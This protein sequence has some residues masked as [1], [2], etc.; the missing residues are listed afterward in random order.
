MS[1]NATIQPQPDRSSP[2]V[3]VTLRI[4]VKTTLSVVAAA[5][6]LFDLLVRIELAQTM[7]RA[8]MA[9][10]FGLSLPHAFALMIGLAAPFALMAGLG[11]RMSALVLGGLILAGWRGPLI[12]PADL[13]LLALLGWYAVRGAGALSVDRV[14]A[15]GL[16]GSALPLAAP[17]M[18][19]LRFASQSLAPVWLLILRLWLAL[20]LLVAAGA[21]PHELSALLPTELY[22]LVVPSSALPLAILLTVGLATPLVILLVFLGL[23]TAMVM[24]GHVG[25]LFLPTLLLGGVSPWHTELTVPPRR[26]SQSPYMGENRGR[27]S[28]DRLGRE[29]RRGAAEG[30]QQPCGLCHD[31]SGRNERSLDFQLH[32]AAAHGRAHRLRNRYYRETRPKSGVR[33]RAVRQVYRCPGPHSGG[34]AASKPR[35]CINVERTQRCANQRGHE[36]RKIEDG[37][38]RYDSDGGEERCNRNVWVGW[39]PERLVS[40]RRDAF[41]GIEVGRA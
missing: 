6:P 38:S 14:I 12:G 17:V 5:R 8:A 25:L 20:T 34:N 18:Q 29:S 23:G 21:G 19:V 11:T 31:D 32:G 4:W 1:I 41:G 22:G 7:L 28:Q 40:K 30:H 26:S 33:R 13:I 39:W 27:E 2:F 15:E 9:M 37:F 16:G 36:S 3:R 24:D 35:G 10:M